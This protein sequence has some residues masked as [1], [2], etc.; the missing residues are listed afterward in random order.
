[1]MSATKQKILVVDDQPENVHILRDL[2]RSDYKIYF[3]L[4][5]NDAL[6]IVTAIHPDLILLDVIMPKLDG[7][8][9]CARIKSRE[10]TQNIPIIFIT[11]KNS[12]EGLQE[13]FY[14]LQTQD[15]DAEQSLAALKQ[16]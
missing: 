1:M 3:A 12:E 5:G 11:A 16:I 14:R 2:L 10:E 9:V 6:D 7:F 15:T 13:L 8:A 4:N